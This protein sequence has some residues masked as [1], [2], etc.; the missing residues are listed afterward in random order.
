MKTE[1]KKAIG[2]TFISYTATS[3]PDEKNVQPWPGANIFLIIICTLCLPSKKTL[4]L[5]LQLLCNT[6]PTR[7]SDLSYMISQ[8]SNR[9][10]LRY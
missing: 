9:N 10:L 7:E 8:K 1:I 6:I 3:S 4:G 2:A 5:L